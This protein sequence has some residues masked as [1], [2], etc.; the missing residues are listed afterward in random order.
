MFVFPAK[1]IIIFFLCAFSCTGK[2]GQK[3]EN[4]IVNLKIENRNWDPDRPDKNVG[5]CAEA[6]IQMALSFY[7]HE[8]S[9][10]KINRAGTPR[11][12]DLYMDDIDEALKGLSITYISWNEKKQKDLEE[13]IEWIKSMLNSGYPVL[14]GVKIYP[15]EKPRWFLDHFVLVVG[16]NKKGFLINTNIKGQKLISYKQLSSFSNGFSF[17]NKHNRYYA[18]AIT[19]IEILAPSMK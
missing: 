10:K 7:G 8:I 19:G 17:R 18:R 14:C 16:Y 15:D 4:M 2:S 1:V 11:H 9:Q 13:F 3:R 6:C 12:S 5:W